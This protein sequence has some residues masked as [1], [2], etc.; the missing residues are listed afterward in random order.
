MSLVK[1]VDQNWWK[2]KKL[3]GEQLEGLAP[4]NYLNVEEVSPSAPA[5]PLLSPPAAAPTPSAGVSRQVSVGPSPAKPATPANPAQPAATSLPATILIGGSV[6]AA[7]PYTAPS[8]P[9]FE[10]AR[11]EVMEV[12]AMIDKNWIRVRKADG[13]AG[14]APVNYL[15][16]LP[17]SNSI[18]L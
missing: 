6:K 5:T 9:A 3:T 15:I 13:V 11:G 18:E 12:V 10:F 16:A 2:V 8:G 14:I 17:P 7:H 1:K 4:L